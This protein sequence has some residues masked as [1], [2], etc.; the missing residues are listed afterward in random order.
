MTKLQVF[1]RVQFIPFISLIISISLSFFSFYRGSYNH[2]NGNTYEVTRNMWDAVF[3]YW[4]TTIYSGD[5]IVSWIHFFWIPLS[6]ILFIRNTIIAKKYLGFPSIKDA[7]H[8]FKELK[9]VKRA[10]L[11]AKAKAEFKLKMEKL[12]EEKKKYL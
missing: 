3:P 9:R 2:W 7:K 4:R 10:S 1:L 8:Y 11:K 12:E 5:R 6:L